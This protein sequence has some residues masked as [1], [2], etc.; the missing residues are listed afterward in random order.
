MRRIKRITCAGDMPEH[1]LQSEALQQFETGDVATCALLRN[2][3]QVDCRLWRRHTEIGD[4]HRART[5][6]E[7]Q[8]RRRDDTKRSF[9]SDEEILQVVAGI[10]LLQ[11]VEVVEHPTVRQ[12]HF[13]TKHMRA[14]NTVCDGGYTTS[15]G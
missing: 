4:F 2:A 11:L 8:H 9:G 5:R 3:K 14:R 13:E 6:H 15:V 10:V 12:H 7:P 1:T